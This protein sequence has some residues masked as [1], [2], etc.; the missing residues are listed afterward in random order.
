MKLFKEEMNK[1]IDWDYKLNKIVFNLIIVGI[2]EKNDE[3]MPAIIKEELKIKSQMETTYIR[4][5]VGKD[6][7][8]K[9]YI[10][11]C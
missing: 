10:D 5:K 6:T 3:H 2:K 11:P 9:I 7:W 8:A 4:K 1:L